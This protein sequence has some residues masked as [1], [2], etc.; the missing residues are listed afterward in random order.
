MRHLDI[1]ER[2]FNVVK[3]VQSDSLSKVFN[4]TLAKLHTTFPESLKR[5]LKDVKLMSSMAWFKGCY[6][7]K[8]QKSQ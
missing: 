4:Q 2:K 7:E 6:S 8:S 3:D 5:H 1:K